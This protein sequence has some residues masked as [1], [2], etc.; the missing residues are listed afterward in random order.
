VDRTG[1]GSCPME[2]FG[3]S[4]VKTSGSATREL[5]SQS[6]SYILGKYVVRMELAQD[7]VQWQAFITAVLNLQFLLTN[8]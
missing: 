6:V 1:S 4:S 8:T 3:I 7:C 2:G 5:E